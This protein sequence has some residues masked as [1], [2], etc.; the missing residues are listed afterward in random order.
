MLVE[1]KNKLIV[2][3]QDDFTE[4]RKYECQAGASHNLSLHKNL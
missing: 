3:N 4:T 2:E 1:G